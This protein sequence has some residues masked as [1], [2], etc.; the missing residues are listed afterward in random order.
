MNWDCQWS[1][2]FEAFLRSI[3]AKS[4]E[5]AK[6]YESTLRR[7]ALACRKHPTHVTRQ[8]IEAFL[9]MPNAAHHRNGGMPPSVGTRNGK[10]A[11]LASFYTFSSQYIPEG[12]AE[13]LFE[14][15][16]PTTGIKGT[17]VLPQPRGLTEAEIDQFFAVIPDDVRGKR[18]RALFLF[19]LI[20]ARRLR[21]VTR[22]NYGSIY[23]G[24]I[25]DDDGSQHQGWLYRWVGKGKSGQLDTAELSPVVKLAIDRYLEA[26]GRLPL[27]EDDP[28]FVGIPYCEGQILDPYAHISL[29]AVQWAVKKYA[30]AAGLGEHVTVHA[31]R[32]SAVQ[33]RWLNGQRDIRSLQRLLR[34]SSSAVTDRYL[35]LLTS[36]S[37]KG[38]AAIESKFAHLSGL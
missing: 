12:Q 20:Q 7:F 27:E 9:S 23:H 13:P 28:L 19:Y 37:D 26:S 5:T 36:T 35:Q 30:R 22:L 29:S 8:D 17:T 14:R 6:N 15:R 10:L 24:T 32:H 18:D 1:Q 2:C 25:I 16:L 4:E 11:I 31:F 21:E 33:Q 34:H 3:R 38:I